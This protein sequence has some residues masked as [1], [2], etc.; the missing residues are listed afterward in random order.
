MLCKL[1]IQIHTQAVNVNCEHHDT[2]LP[3]WHACGVVWW[4]CTCVCVCVCVCIALALAMLCTLQV[5]EARIAAWLERVTWECYRSQDH[6]PHTFPTFV[7]LIASSDTA[8][9]AQLFFLRRVR[10][11]PTE[12]SRVRL[13]IQGLRITQD[14]IQALRGLPAWPHWLA[15]GAKVQWSEDAEYTALA[16]C[17]PISYKL[18]CLELSHD[19]PIIASICEG[20]NQRRAGLGLWPLVVAVSMEGPVHYE[21]RGKHVVLVSCD[22]LSQEGWQEGLRELETSY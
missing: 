3:A 18:W 11:A 10:L 14:A 22:W 19:S 6:E 16:H 2:F 13:T 15:F 7:E 21:R 4:V 9:P 1:Q 17:I 5:S 20:V 8:L 12:P